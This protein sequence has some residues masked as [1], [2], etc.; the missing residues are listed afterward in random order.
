MFPTRFAHFHIVPCLAVLAL[1]LSTVQQIDA[2][3]PGF[4][5]PSLVATGKARTGV[6]A[7]EVE[8]K[9]TVFF[10]EMA[11]VATEVSGKVVDVKFEEGVHVKAGEV[12][13]DLDDSLLHK[14]LQSRKATMARYAAELGDAQTRFERAES[15]IADEI[16]TPQQLDQLRYE[17]ESDRQQVEAMRAEVDRIQTLID[18]NTIRAP[19]DGIVIDR[20]T[21]L[22]EWKAVGDT[23]AVLARENVY[24]VMVSVD[25]V[26]LPWVRVG[27]SVTVQV[28]NSPVDGEIVS[29][30]PQGDMA[31]KMFPVKVRV[32]QEA[33]MYEGMSAF[34]RLPVGEPVDCLFVPRDALLRVGR[35]YIL[36]T[37]ED[38]VAIRHRVEL[39][40]Y[41]GRQNEWAG[42]RGAALGT[43][44]TYIV[45]GHERLQGGEGVKV[46]ERG[47]FDGAELQS[48]DG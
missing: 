1:V 41:D 48:A 40:G 42:I 20:T 12:L 45:K 17:V 35:D 14:D 8:F 32:E 23:V 5:G 4:G 38:G 7:P 43:G 25:E 28:L 2:Q 10:K 13:V 18:K 27:E 37:V 44:H 47:E 36:F 16:T 33:P 24:D 29:I 6:L 19:F 39:L 21:E 9:G 11:E 34:V 15:L 31:S 26:N 30:I 22:G 3:P 46:V